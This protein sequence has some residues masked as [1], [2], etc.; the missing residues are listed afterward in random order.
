MCNSLG[1]YQIM[2]N[3]PYISVSIFTSKHVLR[4]LFKISQIKLV[5]KKNHFNY[6]VK[7]YIVFRISNV[8]C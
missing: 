3:N 2:L 6:T 8:Q 4:K 5:F 1:M 7:K